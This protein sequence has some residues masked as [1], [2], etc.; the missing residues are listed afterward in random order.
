MPVS[1]TRS[2]RQ[3]VASEGGSASARG[4]RLAPGGELGLVTS[5]LPY[6]FGEY[7]RL[8]ADS[9]TWQISTGTVTGLPFHGISAVRSGKG[10][11]GTA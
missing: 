4:G 9:N 7:I 5:R 11:R 6:T 8:E 3:P 10:F 1:R 2:S